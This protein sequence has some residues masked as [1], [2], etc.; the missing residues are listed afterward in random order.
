MTFRDGV[1]GWCC[2]QRGLN[3]ERP[4]GMS[5]F[6]CWWLTEGQCDSGAIRKRGERPEKS[7]D[8]AGTLCLL[9]SGGHQKALG[10]RLQCNLK[11]VALAAHY[12]E[13]CGKHMG[14][15]ELRSGGGCDPDGGMEVHRLRRVLKVCRSCDRL[16]ERRFHPSFRPGC[17][18]LSIFEIRKPQRFVLLPAFIQCC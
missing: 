9:H 2:G 10:R 12:G 16:V 4:H 5:T 17:L 15:G 3:A 18:P 7:R 6:R 1:G 14:W 13:G 8:G 11:L